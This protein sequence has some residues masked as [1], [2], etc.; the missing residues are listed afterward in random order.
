MK[1]AVSQLVLHVTSHFAPAFSVGEMFHH[2]RM[3][4]NFR[5]FGTVVKLHERKLIEPLPNV[6]RRTAMQ[7]NAFRRF[8][9]KIDEMALLD[10]RAPRLEGKILLSVSRKSHTG[11]GKRTDGTVRRRDGALQ[12]T[13][14]HQTLI[15]VRSMGRRQQVLG[16]FGKV[17]LSLRGVN[18][19]VYA[20]EA[21][22][23]AIDIAVHH[24]HGKFEGK[25]TDGGGCVVSNAGQFA[26][27][28]K[29]SR[30]TAAGSDETCCFQ[31]IP[32]PT[33]I[34]QSLPKPQHFVFGGCGER[35]HIRESGNETLIVTPPLHHPRLLQNDF[36]NPNA[37]GVGNVPPRQISTMCRIPFKH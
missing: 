5:H 24:C 10:L 37:I 16:E 15:V 13:E 4:Q 19:D 11:I 35:L 29:G 22:E 36:R 14:I 3:L 32:S 30:E 28:F 33:V 9:I 18:G 31:Q 2:K 1:Q 12:R 8:H 25:G 26:H 34:A 23:N 20:K 17:F 6:T 7:P 21:G 27:L